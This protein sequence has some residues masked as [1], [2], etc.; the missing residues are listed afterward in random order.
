MKK[1]LNLILVLGI[2]LAI[3]LAC[4]FTT[5][6]L[7]DITFAKDQDGD[8]T[9]E[10]IGQG[11]KF[12]ALTSLNNASGKHKVKWEVLD[13]SGEEIE[14]PENEIEVDGSRKLWLTLTVPQNSPIGK[15]K[16]KVTLLDEN[17]EKEIDKKTGT[18]T[19]KGTRS[20]SD[21]SDGE[22]SSSKESD[23]EYDG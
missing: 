16:F 19:V 18:L 23:V 10:S 7:S 21:D 20:G 2:L 13:K 11:G 6:N 8:K 12:F 15:Y 3:G 22:D 17:G 4:N 9:I 14:L 5:A 1:T